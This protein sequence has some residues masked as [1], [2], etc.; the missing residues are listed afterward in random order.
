MKTI[1]IKKG[2][3]EDTVVVEQTFLEKVNIFSPILE[4]SGRMRE[5]QEGNGI[6]KLCLLLSTA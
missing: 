5:R 4:L 3:N 6:R 2:Y 1:H